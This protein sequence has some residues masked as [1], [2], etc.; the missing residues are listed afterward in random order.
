MRKISW[1]KYTS[2]LVIT[3]LIFLL[4]VLLSQIISKRT[5]EDMLK[6][7]KEMGNYLLSLNLQSEIASE[8]I[9]R[10]DVFDLTNEKFNLGK[11]I[12]ILEKNVG[13]E[14]DIVKQLKQ[15]YSL[16]SIR[17]WLLVKKYKD[18]CDP[19]INIIL[20]FYSNEENASE[21]ESQ[22]YVLDY[23]Y[24]KHPENIVT[25]AFDIKDGDPALNT[26]KS[27]YDVKIAPSLIINEKLFIGFQSKEKIEEQLNQT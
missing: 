4:G 19:K 23:L 27:I 1:N 12:D 7:Q 5:S 3:F 15:D 10:V 2:I 22:G 9:C 14:N 20:F 21:S 24:E 11:Q 18:A 8:Y 16:L 13:K 25:Y 6:T 26:I 17:Q